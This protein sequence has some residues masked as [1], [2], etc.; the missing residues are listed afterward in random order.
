MIILVISKALKHFVPPFQ[1]EIF[2][3]GNYRN[4]IVT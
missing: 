3:D 1:A 4:S 2:P